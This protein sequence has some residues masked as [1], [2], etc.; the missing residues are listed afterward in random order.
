MKIVRTNPL[1]SYLDIEAVVQAAKDLECDAVHPG[2]GFLAENAAFVHRLEEE[3]IT[4]IGPAAE[5]ITLLGDKIEARA[6][7]EA[8]GPPH[9]Q[10][11]QR[12]HQRSQAWPRPL[13]TT[14][15]IRSSSRR[16]RAGGGI[17]MQ[18][19]NAADEFEGALRSVSEP[20]EISLWRR[21]RLR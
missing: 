12:A 21:P 13:P 15:D 1:D 16:P 14:S 18:I 20:C 8:A 10:R 5:V 6:A 3:G 2:Y 7:M 11:Q 4:F 17:G 19:V 9:R